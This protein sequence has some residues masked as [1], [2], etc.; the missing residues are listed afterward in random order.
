MV[1]IFRIYIVILM[2]LEMTMVILKSAI[3]HRGFLDTISL[4][5]RFNTVYRR[6]SVTVQHSEHD[7]QLSLAPGHWVCRKFYLLA[8]DRRMLLIQVVHTFIQQMKFMVFT[9]VNI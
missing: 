2:S 9:A 8:V 3:T 1:R 6:I 5:Q 7:K 4:T